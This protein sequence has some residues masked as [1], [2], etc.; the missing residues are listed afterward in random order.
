MSKNKQKTNHLP[1]LI[2]I[3][4]LVGGL[5][6]ILC[7]FIFWDGFIRLIEAFF[8]S[9]GFLEK[10]GVTNLKNL[11]MPMAGLHLGFG[12]TGFIIFKS[13]RIRNI[14]FF[15]QTDDQP[16]RSCRS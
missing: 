13:N 15:I 7:R 3:Y 4:L 6:L 12:L 5:V 2:I 11:M 1:P 16:S 14:P 8:S 9:D 10:N